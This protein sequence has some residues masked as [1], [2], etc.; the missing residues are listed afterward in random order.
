NQNVPPIPLGLTLFDRW[1][2]WRIGQLIAE[3]AKFHPIVIRLPSQGLF[4]RNGHNTLNSQCY[5]K[6]CSTRRRQRADQP[7][8]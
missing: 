6:L 8:T 4:R 5:S 3:R 1:M 2:T 7:P